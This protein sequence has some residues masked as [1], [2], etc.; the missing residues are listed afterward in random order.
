MTRSGRLLAVVVAFLVALTGLGVTASTAQASSSE[1][2]FVSKINASRKAAGRAPLAVSSDLV[3]VARAHAGKMA[4]KQELYH[5]PSL[6]SAVKNW[7][8][9][10]ENVGYGPDIS[11]LHTAFMNSSAHRANILDSRF[12]QVGV[13]VVVVGG[14]MWV[15]EVFRRPTTVTTTKPPAPKPVVTTKPAPKPAPKPVVTTK[16]ASKPVTTP[17]PAPKPAPKPLARPLPVRA[18]AVAHRK[19]PAAVCSSGRELALQLKSLP[20]S[21]RS[22]HSVDRAQVLLLGFQCGHR[23]PT[24]GVLDEA[25]RSALGV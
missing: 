16:P 4:A 13:G 23:L 5:N 22:A 20:A 11:T 19:V 24:T 2:T 10:G 12:T 17:K 7:T 15:T 14:T 25:T 3:A 9:V 8:V 1:S 21:E 6:A 18:S